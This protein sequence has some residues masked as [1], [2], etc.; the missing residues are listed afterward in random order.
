MKELLEL[1]KQHGVEA[2]AIKVF[3]EALTAFKATT[4]K[5]AEALQEESIKTLITEGIKTGIEDRAA[6]LHD[7]I[8]ER[9]EAEATARQT[10]LSKNVAL[11]LESKKE[12]LKAE[13]RRE[14]IEEG[15]DAGSKAILTQVAALVADFYEDGSDEQATK[16]KALEEAL[17]AGKEEKAK[18]LLEHTKLTKRAKLIEEG[19]KAPTITGASVGNDLLEEGNATSNKNEDNVEID[20][21]IIRQ[22]VANLK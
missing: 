20:D 5:E 1:L 22:V 14:V 9:L 3:E 15:V 21:D 17:E 11:Y 6:K 10:A 7:I 18:L 2:S 13:A 8:E 16:I 4:L 12:S 19:L